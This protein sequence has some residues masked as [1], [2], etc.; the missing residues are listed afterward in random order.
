MGGIRFIIKVCFICNL[1][2]L[3]SWML[4]MHEQSGDMSYLSKHAVIMGLIIAA[5]LNILAILWFLAL[6]LRK[7]LIW[8]EAHPILFIFNCIILILQLG[9]V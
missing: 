5:P 7:R 8:K 9:I 2:Y 6:L 1:C 4:R 3:V